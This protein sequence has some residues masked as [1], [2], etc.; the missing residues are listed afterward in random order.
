MNKTQRI[1]DIVKSGEIKIENKKLNIKDKLNNHNEIEY[2]EIDVAKINM[3]LI[4]KHSEQCDIVISGL[5]ASDVVFNPITSNYDNITIL[6]FASS[7]HPGG[8]FIKGSKAQEESLCY[9]SNLYDILSQHKDFYEYNNKHKN[10]S[11]YTDGIIYVRNC[12]FFINNNIEVEPRYCNIITCA[13][14]NRK[15]AKLKRVKDSVINITMERRIKQILEIAAYNKTECLILGAFGC[16]VFGNDP[17]LVAKLFKQYLVDYNYGYYFKKVIFAMN[18]SNDKN[19]I[20]FNKV[21]RR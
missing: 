16:G 14:P 5:G 12:L 7:L 17:N 3:N 15:Q 4:E 11:L 19:A 13:A 6:N 2:R 10:Y 9:A 20:A 18:S 21:F 8:G 1:L